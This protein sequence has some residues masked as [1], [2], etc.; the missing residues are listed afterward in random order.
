[1]RK[2]TYYRLNRAVLL[3][4]TALS[5]LLPLCHF[6]TFGNSPAVTVGAVNDETT[7]EIGIPQML[8]DAFAPVNDGTSRHSWPLVLICIYLTGAIL[9]LAYKTV[10]YVKMRR[11]IRNG[12]LWTENSNADGI[13]IHCKSGQINPFCWMRHIVISEQDAANSEICCTRWPTF[14]AGT[15]GTPYIYYS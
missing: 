5:F 10:D 3:T 2:E 6:P 14:S 13:T 8:N 11:F 15:P 12:N 4:K 1:M 7:I 9:C